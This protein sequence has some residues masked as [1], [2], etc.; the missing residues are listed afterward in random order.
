MANGQ[1]PYCVTCTHFA[2]N[3][4][5]VRNPAANCRCAFHRVKLPFTQTDRLHSLLICREWRH[6]RSG[7]SWVGSENLAD[8]RLYAYG[9]LYDREL[10]DFASI[11]SLPSTES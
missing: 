1:E 4:G 2:S 9:S 11:S 6:Y 5:D 10:E 8:G 3:G 7:K